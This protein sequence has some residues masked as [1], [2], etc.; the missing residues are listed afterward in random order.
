MVFSRSWAELVWFHWTA[1][2]DEADCSIAERQAQKT[3]SAIA[4]ADFTPEQRLKHSPVSA[5]ILLDRSFI[6]DQMQASCSRRDWF[7]IK[8]QMNRPLTNRPSPWGRCSVRSQSSFQFR[9][10]LMHMPRPASARRRSIGTL[11]LQQHISWLDRQPLHQSIWRF[12]LS[13]RVLT[14]IIAD[15]WSSVAS[16]IGT[17]ADNRAGDAPN[18]SPPPSPRNAVDDFKTSLQ[19]RV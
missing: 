10:R 19:F 5:S 16:F 3:C 13:C 18:L 14:Y 2:S 4:H 11:H 8:K 7:K 17:Q 6:T 12:L 15:L 1:A 9:R